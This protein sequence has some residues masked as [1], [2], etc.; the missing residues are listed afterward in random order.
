MRQALA[1]SGDHRSWNNMSE[2]SVGINMLPR[3]KH[4]PAA[5]ARALR[6][7]WNVCFGSAADMCTRSRMSV[8]PESGR[9]FLAEPFVPEV[10]PPE[11]PGTFL[12]QNRT[13]RSV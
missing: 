6:S 2:P 12:P 13:Y 4:W 9:P 8:A 5:R 11:V 3:R 10:P 7:D 1:G